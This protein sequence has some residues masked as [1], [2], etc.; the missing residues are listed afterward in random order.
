M[1]IKI[2]NEEFWLVRIFEPVK[3]GDRYSPIGYCRLVVKDR[4][5]DEYTGVIDL[6]YDSRDVRYRQYTIRLY[7]PDTVF[8]VYDNATISMA[9]SAISTRLALEEL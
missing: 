8:P 1:W 3:M 9:Y 4:P 2:N 6:Y 5:E 7:N